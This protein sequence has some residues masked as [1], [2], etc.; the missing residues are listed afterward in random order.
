LSLHIFQ[1]WEKKLM[2]IVSYDF[3]RC[4]SFGTYVICSV[5]LRAPKPT[6]ST[7]N[8]NKTLISFF[9]YKYINILFI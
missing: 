1:T 8:S 6:F 2:R 7:V 9:K 5:L 3:Y 4:N